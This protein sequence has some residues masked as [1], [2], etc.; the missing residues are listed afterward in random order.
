MINYEIKY[1]ELKINYDELKTKYDILNLNTTILKNDQA[2]RHGKWSRTEVGKEKA[3]VNRLKYYYKKSEKYHE[4]YNPDVSL[5]PFSFV[6]ICQVSSFHNDNNIV[7]FEC[8]YCYNVYKKCGIMPRAQ[9]TKISHIYKY[10]NSDIDNGYIT[11]LAVC[12]RKY[13]NKFKIKIC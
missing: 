3:R 1:K 12:Q 8:P 13:C 7:K 5:L 4:I 11:K 6:D 10:H 9:S 2:S